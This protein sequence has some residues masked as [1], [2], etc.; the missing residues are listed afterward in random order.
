MLLNCRFLQEFL[1]SRCKYDLSEINYHLIQFNSKVEINT[2]IIIVTLQLI[3]QVTSQR[4]LLGN[5]IHVRFGLLHFA[6][7]RLD[8]DISAS[9]PSVAPVYRVTCCFLATIKYNRYRVF[10]VGI[11]PSTMELHHQAKHYIIYIYIYKY[12][13][14]YIYIFRCYTLSVHS[15]EIGF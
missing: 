12:I 4:H 5:E 10:P 6:A 14:I 9:T 1:N 13:C 7:R 8:T 11:R 15:L 3:M 2:M